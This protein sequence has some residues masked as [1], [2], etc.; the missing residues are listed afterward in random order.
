MQT[1]MLARVLADDVTRCF[2]KIQ[3][4]L[5]KEHSKNE[6]LSGKCDSLAVRVKTLEEQMAGLRSE[7]EASQ[8]A[9]AFAEEEIA[10]ERELSAN[11]GA[12]AFESL[13]MLEDAVTQLGA[14]P[15]AGTHRP[16]ET[17]ITFARLK[18]VARVCVPAARSYGDHCAKAAWCEALAL[19][20]KVGCAHID[21]IATRSV[22]VATAEEVASVERRTRKASKVLL[23]D[24]WA[25]RGHED[26]TKS[27]QELQ[28]RKAKGKSPAVEPTEAREDGKRGSLRGDKV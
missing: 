18:N 24:Y 21:A 12:A 20:D 28:A 5:E 3:Q 14:V 6:A 16:A 7:L 15:S 26:A 23:E 1:M 13:E 2:G 27:F 25:L 11:M 9:W 4:E 8:Q 10:V 17:D 19:L 22:A